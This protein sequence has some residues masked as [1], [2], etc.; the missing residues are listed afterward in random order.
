MEGRWESVGGSYAKGVVGG[1]GGAMQC[2]GVGPLVAEDV[3]LHCCSVTTCILKKCPVKTYRAKRDVVSFL[4]QKKMY[5]SAK[6]LESVNKSLTGSALA[7]EKP[8]GVKQFFHHLD[9]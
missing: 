8:P 6:K 5:S 2:G 1:R 4:R 9:L 3:L 7:G